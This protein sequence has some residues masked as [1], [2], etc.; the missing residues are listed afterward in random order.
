MTSK[1]QKLR[2]ATAI[3]ADLRS[4]SMRTARFK[5]NVLGH[6]DEGVARH[7]VAPVILNA[8]DPS[9]V[10]TLAMGLIDEQKRE[11]GATY[12]YCICGR[13]VS[14]SNAYQ[15]AKKGR[16]PVCRGCT[17]ADKRS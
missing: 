4:P 1:L 14:R 3:A 9:D 12:A 17:D 8:S 13:H 16:P 7:D 10:A 5:A 15:A 2:A 6:M 11:V